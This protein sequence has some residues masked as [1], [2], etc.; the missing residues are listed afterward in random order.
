MSIALIDALVRWVGALLAALTLGVIFYGLLRG[1]QRRAGRS[2]GRTG[3]WVRSPWFYLASSALYFGICTIGWVPLPLNI[4]PS[5]QFWML[6]IGSLFYFPGMLLVLWGR[7]ALGENYFVSSG[8][9]AQLFAGHRLVTSGPYALVRHPM[10]TGIFLAAIGSLLIY[11][12]WTTLTFVCIAPFLSFRARQ[13]EA[14]LSA[15]FSEQ[16]WEYC[17]SVPPFLPRLKL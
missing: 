17:Q 16:W 11:T 5:T 12:T 3:S 2:T 9:G 10:Y 4:S 7:L 6:I 8:F 15:E 13:E 14:A 1:T